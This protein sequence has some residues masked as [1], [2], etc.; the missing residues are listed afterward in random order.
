M[1]DNLIRSFLTFGAELY[2]LMAF[3]LRMPWERKYESPLR[4]VLLLCL[5]LA[6]GQLILAYYHQSLLA[7]R[8]Y[9]FFGNLT[10][11]YVTVISVHIY[12][13]LFVHDEMELTRKYLLTLIPAAALFLVEIR[14]QLSSA[15]VRLQDVRSIM[16][17]SLVT[18]VNLFSVVRTSI[19]CLHLFFVGLFLVRQSGNR[20]LAVDNPVVRIAFLTAMLGLLSAVFLVNYA[21]FDTVSMLKAAMVMLNFMVLALLVV[22]LRFPHVLEI[23]KE[24]MIRGRYLRSRLEGVDTA[25]L[26]Q[27]LSRLMDAENLYR[28]ENLSLA[29]LARRV[30]VTPHQLSEFLNNE[31]QTNF[32]SYINMFRIEHA[33]RMLREQ[34]EE[35]I[36]NIAFAAGFN[37]QSTFYS[38]FLKL[39]GVTPNKYR[40]QEAPLA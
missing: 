35:T 21:V 7:T 20:P 33:K 9:L 28:E 22:V 8:P 34:P 26:G 16:M 18:G 23:V 1:L 27:S 40:K 14:V 3:T 24:E 15:P 32:R 30:N 11:L 2:V 31:L 10:L 39:T 13:S 12:R 17:G 29:K 5:G 25:S 19:F 36:L 6:Q 38:A 37:S 4:F